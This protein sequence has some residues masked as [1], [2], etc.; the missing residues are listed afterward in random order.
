MQLCLLRFDLDSLA[1]TSCVVLDNADHQRVTDGYYAVAVF[2]GEGSAARLHVITYKA[3]KGA[4]P[5]IVRFDYRW[6]DVK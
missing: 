4:P 2:T 5:D 6:A 1:V 3:L